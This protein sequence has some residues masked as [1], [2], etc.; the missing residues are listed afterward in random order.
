MQSYLYDQ[1]LFSSELISAI[2]SAVEQLR[3]R[4]RAIIRHLFFDDLT[5][6]EVAHRAGLSVVELTT[7]VEILLAKLRRVV[8]KTKAGGMAMR[9]EEERRARAKRRAKFEQFAR[10]PDVE[11]ELRYDRHHNRNLLV[12]VAA[13]EAAYAKYNPILNIF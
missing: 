6:R 9:L 2:E 8:F 10:D 1:E 13:N 7:V 3:P 12:A 4:H 11:F 5:I